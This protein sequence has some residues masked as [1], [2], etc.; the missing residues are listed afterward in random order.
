MASGTVATLDAGPGRESHDI[1]AAVDKLRAGDTVRLEGGTYDVTSFV[2]IPSG[3]TLDFRDVT[4]RMAYPGVFLKVLPGSKGVSLTGRLTFLGNGADAAGMSFNG[5]SEIRVSLSAEIVGLAVRKPFLLIDQCR[6]VAVSG[7]YRTQDSRILLAVDSSNVEVGG[8]EAGPFVTDPGDSIVRA[9]STGA[10]G[11]VAGISVHDIN[12]DGG[13]RLATGG[14]VL[15]SAN[16][17]EPDIQKVSIARCSAKNSLGTVDGVDVNRC[18][19]VVVE[20]IYG[21]RVNVALAVVASDARVTNVE[22][23]HCRAQ[24][25]EYG[26]PKYQTESISRAVA[27]NLKALDCGLGWNGVFGAGI[28][29]FNSPSTTT[30]NVVLRDVTSEDS[31]GRSQKYGLGMTS[32]VRSVQVLGGRLHGFVGRTLNQAPAAELTLVQVQ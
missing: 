27:Q 5:S 16:V 15:V 12:V 8:V 14:A 1:Q 29:I 11:P 31:D 25:F 4:V 23:H 22:G 9:V 13:G 6:E 30:S 28:G 10:H 19:N 24:A 26:D 18:S 21:E 32:G 3:V 20:D 7:P 17:G 2:T